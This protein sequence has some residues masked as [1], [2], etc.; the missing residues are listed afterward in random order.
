MAADGSIV[1]ETNLDSASAQKELNALA[2]KINS[3]QKSLNDLGSKRDPL[4][5]QARNYGAELD[6]AKAKLE[7]LKAEQAKTS[8]A[9]TSGSSP[10]EYIEAYGKKAELDNQVAAQQQKVDALQAEWDKV[11]TKVEAYDQKI[12]D[13]NAELDKSVERAGELQKNMIKAGDGGEKMDEATKKADGSLKSFGK[14]L[15]QLAR[16]ALVFSAITL[17]LTNLRKWLGNALKGN[18][19]FRQSIA[20]LKGALLTAFQPIM[21]Y[22]VPALTTLVNVLA[23]VVWHVAA[24]F[25]ALSGKTIK[26]TAEAAKNTYDQANA[27]EA[28]G[29][30]ASDATKAMASFDEIN[31]ISNSSG[32]V[33]GGANSS[34]MPDFDGYT[35]LDSRLDWL[36]EDLEGIGTLVAT[37]GAGFLAWKIADGILSALGVMSGNMKTITAGLVLSVVGFAVEAQGAFELGRGNKTLMNYL[38]TAL[39]GALGVGAGT[40][41]LASAGLASGLAF[42]ISLSVGILVFVTSMALGYKQGLIDQ[43]YTT[44]VGKV[45]RDLETKMAQR[46]AFQLDL[47]AR[48]DN[49]YAVIDDQTNAEFEIAAQ[50]ISDI[51]S[52]N[53]DDNHTAA[54][55]EVVKAKI[56]TLNNMGLDGIQL[57]FD[58]TTGK[59][60]G[61]K[62]EILQTL[63]ALKQQYAL[64]ALSG[65][66]KEAVVARYDAQVDLNKAISENS[67]AADNYNAA[68]QRQSELEQALLDKQ[69]EYRQYLEDLGYTFGST[70]RASVTLTEEQKKFNEEIQSITDE[71]NANSASVEVLREAYEGTASEIEEALGLYRETETAVQDVSTAMDEWAVNSAAVADSI[72]E[73]GQRAM[74]GFANGITSG[75]GDAA[76]AMT[77][78]Q[79]AIWQAER[80]LNK[81]NSPSKTYE[82]DGGFI[83][84]GL[85][86]GITGSTSLV[87]EAMK[88]LLNTLTGQVEWFVNS[89]RSAMNGLMQDFAFAMMSLEVD[90]SGSVSYTPIAMPALPRLA[91]GAV[92]PANREFLAV[93]G[94]QKSGTNIETPLSTMVDAFNMALRQN[95]GGNVTIRFDGDLA[96]LG[97]VLKPVI[98]R[99]SNRRGNVLV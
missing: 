65:A 21:E 87:V 88:S 53:A 13:A 74:E 33:G 9:L 86:N 71:I 10:S 75:A 14:R 43:F 77:A 67:V 26:Q 36:T 17:A 57:E 1:I 28:L 73:D 2:K 54:E 35:E 60:K 11:V 16:G 5:E 31:Q 23:R 30:A 56:D 24:F 92:I 63:D 47:R 96:Q 97:R 51:F 39:G 41:A 45:T 72:G 78:A 69:G 66:F 3:L 37:I 44:E 29:G 8:A 15:F 64:E 6:A 4:A 40:V 76:D 89:C 68:I 81:I 49:I 83:M 85:A 32:G 42:V 38:K 58:E 99:E 79:T 95:G 46:D 84:Q 18:E 12:A 61:T 70:S 98:D 48:I 50:L 80:D 62:E 52:F 55:I 59:V 82:E 93:L 19:E 27:M 90:G 7:A 34:I 20:S 91:S 22:I 94:D 25:A